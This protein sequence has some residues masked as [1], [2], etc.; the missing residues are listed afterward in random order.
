MKKADELMKKKGFI[1]A[2]LDKAVSSVE[3]ALTEKRKHF[4]TGISYEQETL[5]DDPFK[6]NCK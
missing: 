2:E 5:A 1:K 4:C 3:R 6:R